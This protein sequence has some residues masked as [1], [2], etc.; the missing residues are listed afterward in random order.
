MATQIQRHHPVVLGK[1]F[2]LRLPVEARGT[3][4]VQQQQQGALPRAAQGKTVG[5]HH[6][7]AAHQFIASR[8]IR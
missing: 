6:L 7:I 1:T 8:L 5:F 4:P 2:D 3:Q